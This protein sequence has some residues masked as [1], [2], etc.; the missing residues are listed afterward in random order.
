MTATLAI[1]ANKYVG[2]RREFVFKVDGDRPI[3]YP[4]DYIN[5]HI[6]FLSPIQGFALSLMN[7]RTAF[8][9]IERMFND[10][11]PDSLATLANVLGSVDHLVRS[12]VS[13]TGIGADG[14]IKV[15]DAPL[16]HAPQYDPREFVVSPDDFEAVMG[17]VKRRFRLRAPINVYTVT[18]HRC[19]TDCLYCYAD[20]KK[21]AEMPLSRWRELIAEMARLG[22]RLC[23]PDNG[24]TF[25]R[26]DGIDILECMIEHKMHFLLSTKAHLTRDIVGRLFEAGFKEKINGVIDRPVQLSVDA[27]DNDIAKRILNVRKPRV[28]LAADTFANFMHHGIM[29]IIKCVVTGLNYDQIRRIVDY[30]YPRGARAFTFVRYTRSF[31]RHTDDLF[32]TPT[33]REALVAQFDDI[34]TRYPDITLNENMSMAPSAVTDLTPE[35]RQQLWDSRL[36]CGG[37]WYALGIGPDGKAFLCEQMAYE[38]PYFVGNASYQS[39]ADIWDNRAMADFIYPTREQYAGTIC[40]SCGS[41]QKCMWEKGR[42]YRDAYYSYGSIYATPPMCPRNDQPSIRLS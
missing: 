30:F 1:G 15:S 42:C 37:G 31:H 36:G 35:R 3:L 23:S 19:H 12:H 9:E 21:T 29:P 39:I 41:F 17:N 18:T 2:V 33:H 10:L 32:L 34:R 4:L 28:D 27:V 25:A 22:I 14:I 13:Q 20:R 8:G 40:H 38:E 16:P 11:F 7:G 26:K 6:H 5:T 24:E